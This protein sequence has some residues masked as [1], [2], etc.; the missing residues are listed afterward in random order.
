MPL[1]FVV[2]TTS[3]GADAVLDGSCDNGAG[4][5]TLRAAIQESNVSPNGAYILFNVPGPGPHAI[6]LGA[7]LPHIT[8]DV[9]I[10][11][12]TGDAIIIDGD[13]QHR[14]FQVGAGHQLTLWNLTIANGAGGVRNAGGMVNVKQCTF[15]GNSAPNG[16]AIANILGIANISNSTFSG[17]DAGGASGAMH[18]AAG[19]AGGGLYNGDGSMFVSNSTLSGNTATIGGGWRNVTGTLKMANTIVAGNVAIV[20]PDCHNTGVYTSAGFNLVGQNGLANG[21]PTVLT[22]TLL[23][24]PISTAL[25]PTLAPN[26]ALGGAPPTLALVGGSPAVDGGNPA[27]CRALSGG[28]GNPA[29]N[30]GDPILEDERG[31]PRPFPPGGRCDIGAYEFQEPDARVLEGGVDVPDG[32]GIVGFGRTGEGEPVTRTFTVSNTGNV[33]LTVV[34]PNV[35]PPDGFTVVSSFVVTQVLPGHAT[36][37][38]VRLDAVVTGSYSATVTFPNT[39]PDENPYNFGIKG[40]VWHEVFLPLVLRGS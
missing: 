37:F 34:A 27:G 2:D 7:D 17:N 20:D 1:N 10:G 31:W 35:T 25:R 40:E 9:G 14:I 26:E 19:G 32:T 16:G 24:G 22:D 18:S 33:T 29:F 21:C 3:D 28:R 5:C 4:K 8:N 23:S 13:N 39:D 30:D 12:P 36:L 6:T 15:I 38:D 11:N